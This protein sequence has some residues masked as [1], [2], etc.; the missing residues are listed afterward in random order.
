LPLLEGREAARRL[1]PL[2]GTGTGPFGRCIGGRGLLPGEGSLTEA[3][4]IQRARQ[5]DQAA[6]EALVRLHQEPAFRLAYLILGD[7][8]EAKDV[9]QMSFLRAFRALSRFDL[10]RPWRPWFLRITAN[11]ARNQRRAAARHL[12]ALE[13][14]L[15]LDLAG[16]V[17]GAREE[18]GPA[19]LSPAAAQELWRAVR[20]LRAG[21]QDVI[22]MR[23]FL[24]LPETEMAEALGVAKGTVKS[25]LHRAL[26]RLRRKIEY[27]YPGLRPE[28][29]I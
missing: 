4:I 9:V 2:G 1:G 20:S 23:F 10:G 26:A 13:R 28:W 21:D 11:Q 19:P 25:R 14:L 22:F 16:G 18:P 5:G 17:A 15:R 3:E 7:P 6:L 29:D 24:E 12:A 27:E 8:E